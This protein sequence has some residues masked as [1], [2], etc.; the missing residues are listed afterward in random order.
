MSRVSRLAARLPF[1][2]GWVI[3]GVAFVT[4]ALAVNARTAF[5]LLF[6]PIL[7]EFGWDRADTAGAFSFGFLVSAALGP[8][9]GRAMERYG[10]VPVMQTGV[11]SSGIGMLLAGQA[12]SL[13]Q[14]YLSLGLLVGFGSVCLGYTGHGLFL[15]AWFSRRRG[16]ALSLAFAGVGA[17]SVTLL[18]FMQFLIA[19]EGW[20]FACMVF[21]SLILIVLVPLNFLVRRRPSDLGLGPDGDSATRVAADLARGD[22]VVDPA[23][24]R[25]EWTLSLALRTSRFW[26]IALA[27]SCGLFSWYAVQVHQTRYLLEVG[28]DA[29]TAGWALG[30]VSLAGI[31]GQIGLGWLSDRIGREIVWTVGCAGFAIC[32]L[33]LIGLYFWPSLPLLVLMVIAQGAIGYGI[34]AVFGAIPADVFESPH[35]GPIFGTISLT[36]ISGGALGPWI[37]GAVHDATGSYAPA[38][39]LAIALTALS[40]FAI[41]RAAPG[42]VRA[43]PGRAIRRSPQPEVGS[44]S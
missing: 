1:F 35:Y 32:Y 12:S 15:P 36:A 4:M 20:R 23:W 9:M 41:W 7:D 26:W 10:P 16:L 6:P 29:V 34:T 5:S 2:Y 11:L 3:V 17:G 14:F 38:F 19:T 24:T 42:S 8:W 21:G 39:W 27:Y 43:V 30:I 28:F 22:T 33:A 40:A 13:W 25:T 44:D 31:P 18:P 37:T